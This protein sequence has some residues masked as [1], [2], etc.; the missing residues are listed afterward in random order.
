MNETIQTLRLIFNE[1]FVSQRDDCVPLNV[2]LQFEHLLHYFKR[3]KHY[4]NE[5]LNDMKWWKSLHIQ[6]TLLG[7]DRPRYS[8]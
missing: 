5:A 1:Y 2:L 8:R 6:M 7:T 3:P 4:K